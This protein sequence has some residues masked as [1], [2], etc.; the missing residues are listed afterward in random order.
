MTP[1]D[2]GQAPDLPAGERLI[3]ALDLPDRPGAEALVETLGDRA[4]F[5]KVGLELFAAGDGA[6]LCRA[7]A[8]AGKRVFADLKLFD[9]PETVGRA[10]ARVADLGADFVTVHGDGAILESAVR[11]AG[12]TGVLA[13]TVLTSLDRGGLEEMGLA[14]EPGVLALARAR[15]ASDLGCAGVVASGLDAARVRG[16]IRPG[17]AVVTPGVRPAADSARGDQRRV[18]LIEDAVRDG[19]DYVVVGRPIRDADDPAAAAGDAVGRI[20]AGLAARTRGPAVTGPGP[21]PPGRT[22]GT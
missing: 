20:R 4:S 11:R 7:L 21:L 10:A 18:A 6:P 15:L 1:Q 12:A 14:R 19:A 13:V 2:G 9:I 8:R 17:M 22:G 5:Y 16:A 3:V